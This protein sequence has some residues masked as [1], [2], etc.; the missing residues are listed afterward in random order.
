MLSRMDSENS[1]PWDLAVWDEL[2]EDTL[3]STRVYGQFAHFL[4]EVYKHK[5]SFLEVATAVNYLNCLINM[6]SAKFKSSGK[7]ETRLFFT[8]LDVNASTDAAVWLRGV[9]KNTQRTF[10]LRA[11]QA[12]TPMDK[13]EVPI[14]LLH[15]RAMVRTTEVHCTQRGSRFLCYCLLL[16]TL[17]RSPRPTL[18]VVHIPPTWKEQGLLNRGIRRLGGAK[19]H[20]RLCVA[21]RWAHLGDSVDVGGLPLVRPPL[22]LRSRR[23]TAVQ[24]TEGQ[25]YRLCCRG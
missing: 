6:A 11:Q 8:C 4:T 16:L 25:N 12:G 23:G 14:Y 19:V 13:S 22:H 10:F 7:A 17:H 5:S 3:C 2:D 15:L 21:G 18:L 20:S 1:N 9:R 24:E